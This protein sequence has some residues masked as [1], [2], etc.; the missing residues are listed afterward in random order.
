MRLESNKTLH[1]TIVSHCQSS[2]LD[3]RKSHRASLVKA[4][5]AHAILHLGLA[6]GTNNDLALWAGESYGADL[7]VVAVIEIHLTVSGALDGVARGE[8][9]LYRAPI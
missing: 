1:L 5:N 2:T 7:A 8:V 6:R 9:G 4:S 3:V